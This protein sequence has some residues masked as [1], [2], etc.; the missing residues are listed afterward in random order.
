[1][2]VDREAR[3]RLI[4]RKPLLPSFLFVIRTTICGILHGIVI[5]WMS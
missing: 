2:A 5:S 3:L 4:M 1:M